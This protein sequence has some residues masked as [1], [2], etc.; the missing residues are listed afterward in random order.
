MK[1][2]FKILLIVLGVIFIILLV[3]PIFLKKPLEKIAKEQI[4][5]S[6]NAKVDF[7]GLKLSLIRNFPNAYVALED[8]TIVGIGDFEKDTLLSFKTFSVRI[9]II[10]AIKMTNIKVKSILLDEPRVYAHILKNGKANWDIVKPS[11]EV[12]PADTLP[13]EEFNFGA[14]LKKFEI[15]KAYIKY[16]DDTAKM[17]AVI[18][19]LNFLLSGN[20][21]AKKD[22][23]EMTSTIGALDFLMDDIK[24]IKQATVGF[25]AKI[26]ADLENGIYTFKENEI[27]LN[28][29]SLGI[30]GVVKMP[31]DTIETD[32]SF[33][34]NK[35]DFKTLLSMVPAIYMKDFT[36]LQVAG[37]LKLEGF[38]KGIYYDKKMPNVGL[39]LMVEKAMFRY[40]DL[41]KSV[42]NIN[43]DLKVYYDGTQTDNSTVDL[44]RFHFE[45]AGNPFDMN[46]HIKT[47][48]SDMG[49]NGGLA[50]K[51]DF[52]SLADA[53]H[54]DSM[55]IKG[56]LESDL[57]LMCKMSAIDQQKYEDV[58]ANG[59]MKLTNF[60]FTSND[61]PQGF[62]IIKATMAFSPKFVELSEF[63]SR[64]GKS[65]FQLSGKLEKFIPY[66]F[67]NGTIVGT[68]NF[69][70]NL[71]DVNEFLTGESVDQAKTQDTS[72]L[73]LFEVPERIDFTLNSKIGQ[74]NYDK[75]KINDIVGVIFIRNRK[76][77]LQNLGMNLLEGTMTM[78]GEYNT[79]D[80]KSPFFDFK[81]KMNNIDIPSAYT[82]FNTIEKLAPIAQNCKGKIS[83]DMG[84]YSI[85]DPHMMPVY[86][87]M[88]GSG[89]LMSKNVEIGNSN[90][91]IKIADYLKNDK[92]RKLTVNDLN[93]KFSIKN[94]RVY[95]DPFETKLGSTKML[96]GGDQGMDQTLNYLVKLAIPLTEF[97]G[98]ANQVLDNLTSNAVARGLNIQPSDVVNVDIGVSGTFLKPEIKPLLASSAKGSILDMKTQLMSTATEKVEDVKKQASAQAKAQAD[99]IIKEA[100]DKARKLKDAAAIAAENEKK[101]ANLAADKVVS[102]AGTNPLLKAAAKKTADK[103]RKEGDAKATKIVEKSNAQA[104]SIVNKARTEAAKLE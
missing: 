9:N 64:M 79:Q 72:Q 50:G 3:A 75:L 12:T 19:D 56:I 59:S 28:E 73:T 90:T 5:K 34:T 74:L 51:I 69:S 21:S 4:N 33:K 44:D 35:A 16:Q 78:N 39:N 2:F 71:I 22:E 65:D 88:S 45:L 93:L 7:S 38:V 81:F 17:T 97:G 100:E 37:L 41:P 76:A 23:M 82:A 96:I 13:S 94:G 58:K 27:R 31:G 87:S 32:L 101:A 91:F 48:I 8:F 103:L 47:P 89:Q 70:S 62:K 46:L 57:E 98:T 25:D 10:S 85:L 84:I 54:L 30:N 83:A 49:I 18:N 86:T 104:D 53:I 102:E 24:Y 95:V 43:I 36:S 80:I 68:L 66:V 92:F 14:N 52:T 6:L 77:V 60:E 61:L 63:D 42:D 67:H 1:K 99:K 26:S 11:E 29:L 20:F 40:P 15:R 55:T